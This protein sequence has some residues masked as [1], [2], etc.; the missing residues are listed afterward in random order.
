M[1]KRKKSCIPF[2]FPD[3]IYQVDED[4]REYLDPHMRAQREYIIDLL[5]KHIR[6]EFL[7]EQVG[8]TYQTILYY[9]KCRTQMPLEF[10]YRIEKGLKEKQIKF[11]NY[12]K[13]YWS[14]KRLY[15]TK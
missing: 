8:V 14:T 9:L 7:A 10:A 11:P 6:V 15:I 5:K 4:G 2:S 12:L 1:N 13:K 3:P